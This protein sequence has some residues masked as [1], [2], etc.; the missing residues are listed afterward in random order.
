MKRDVTIEYHTSSS[1]SRFTEVNHT[2]HNTHDNDVHFSD[3]SSDYHMSYTASEASEHC[4][5]SDHDMQD[6]DDDENDNDN[7]FCPESPSPDSIRN[8]GY[9]CLQSVPRQLLPSRQLFHSSPAAINPESL[10]LDLSHKRMRRRFSDVQ[11]GQPFRKVARRMFTNSR[12]RW[13]QQ[14]VNGAFADLR[15]LVP[16]YPPDKKLSKNEILRLAIRYIK[17]LGEVLEYRKEHEL[18]THQMMASACSSSSPDD[19]RADDNDENEDD[20]DEHASS[21]DLDLDTK[22]RRR[23]VSSRSESASVIQSPPTTSSSSAPI[24][25]AATTKTSADS[26][27]HLT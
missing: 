10:P 3:D 20:D 4:D 18:A 22:R 12:E 9:I 7:V 15:K 19:Q 17:L 25:V 11:I 27:V 24:S 21:N 5:I 23:R 13:R 26:S 8:S 16:T 1:A 14:N 2:R 6:D